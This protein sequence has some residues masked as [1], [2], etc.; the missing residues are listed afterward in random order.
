MKAVDTF[1]FAR[2]TDEP[3]VLK[4]SPLMRQAPRLAMRNLLNFY[5]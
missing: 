1:R 3:A 2:L 5:P 4:Q